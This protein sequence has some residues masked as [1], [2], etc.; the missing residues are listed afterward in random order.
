VRSDSL[1]ARHS[2]LTSPISNADA[3][4]LDNPKLPNARSGSS[5]TSALHAQALDLDR[6]DGRPQAWPHLHGRWALIREPHHAPHVIG[7]LF[8]VA[9]R[10]ITGR[11]Q[12]LL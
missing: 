10:K 1:S 6:G 8:D 4:L 7:W 12:Q 2:P 9:L 5:A 3:R 11:K